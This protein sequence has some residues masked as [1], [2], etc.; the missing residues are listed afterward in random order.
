M[1][2]LAGLLAAAILVF[3]LALWALRPRRGHPGWEAL[4]AY[5]YAHRGLHDISAGRPENSL[6]AFRAAAEAGFGAELDVHLM[7]D[8]SLAVVHDRELE[9][10]CGRHAV[11]EQLRREELADYPLLGSGET[12]PLFEDVLAV[13]RGKGPLI[14]ELKA[15]RGNAAALADAVMEHLAGWQGMYCMESFDPAVLARLR[16]KWPDVLRGQLSQNFWGK[17]AAHTGLGWAADL[18]MTHLLVCAA[19]RPDF[20]AYRW[21]DRH[22]R[23]LRLMKRLWGVHEAAWTVRDQKRME[24]LEADGAV[25]IFEGFLPDGPMASRPH[26]EKTQRIPR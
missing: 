8:G 16:K 15:A 22:V 7:A 9:R 17:K 4:A 1:W 14:I 3:L 23:A 10:V 24:A 26:C 21:Q 25:V 6:S 18:A 19:G 2:W 11:I 20:I 13:F 12:I 5:R